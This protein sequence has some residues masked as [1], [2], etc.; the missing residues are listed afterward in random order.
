MSN[1]RVVLL[2]NGYPYFKKA[3]SGR[4]TTVSTTQLKLTWIT[5]LDSSSSIYINNLPIY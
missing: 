4:Q 2:R 1:K 3:E 5:E